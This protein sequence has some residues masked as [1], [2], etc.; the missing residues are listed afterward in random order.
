MGRKVICEMDLNESSSELDLIHQSSY[1]SAK[2]NPISGSIK[3]DKD[4]LDTY[5]NRHCVSERK[6][7]NEAS[8]SGFFWFLLLIVLIIIVTS[9]VMM[10][11]KSSPTNFGSFSY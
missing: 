1:R 2:G 5:I 6:L 7:K 8:N 3:F 4:D 9:S 10:I 11:P